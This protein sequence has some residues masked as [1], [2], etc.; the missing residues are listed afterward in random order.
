MLE[1]M[2][3]G[4][5]DLELLFQLNKQLIDTYEDTA[6][7]DYDRVL[8]WVHK[9]LEQTLPHFT[10]VLWNEETAG[11]YALTPVEDKT[12]LDSLFVLPPFQNRGIGTQILRRCTETTQTPL[13]LYVFRRNT[14]AIRLYERL[15]F[16]ITI[17]VG[18]T[19]YIM[20]YAKQG[21]L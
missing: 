20:E 14:S 16:R 13:F 7:I 6:A 17:E 10:R 12:E 8:T 4:P 21:C 5:E 1:F 2:P 19:R 9:N 11:F 18:K 3:A 15:G